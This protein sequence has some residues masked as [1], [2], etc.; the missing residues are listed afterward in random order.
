MIAR[1]YWRDRRWKRVEGVVC[2]MIFAA[3]GALLAVVLVSGAGK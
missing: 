2:C 1:D 3:L